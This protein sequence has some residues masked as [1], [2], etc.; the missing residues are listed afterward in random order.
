MGE[1]EAE[2]CG[3]NVRGGSGGPPSGPLGLPADGQ[4]GVR[5]P[6]LIAHS[7]SAGGRRELPLPVSTSCKLGG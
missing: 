5:D 2:G 6:I 4:E 1:E 7:T 3:L